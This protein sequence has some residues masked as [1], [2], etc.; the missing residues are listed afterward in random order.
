MEINQ[1]WDFNEFWNSSKYEGNR[2]YKSS[3]QPS[4]VYAV[5][6]DTDAPGEYF[7]NPIG[8][9][10]YAGEDGKLY[11][12]ISTFTSALQIVQKISVIVK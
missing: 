8:H 12:D 3:C 10:H 9:G 2:H 6:I 11:T 5:T 1:P 4:L 7:L